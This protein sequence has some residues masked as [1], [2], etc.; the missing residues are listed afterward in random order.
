MTKI[1]IL[2]VDP[3]IVATGFGLISLSK[4]GI[5]SVAGGTVRP[6]TKLSMGQRLL[7]IETYLQ[8]LLARWR[9]AMGAMEA[10]FV[11]RDPGAALKLGGVAGVC[12]ST[13]ARHGLVLENM[14]PRHIK[15]KV[16]GRGS[17]DK[18]A[19]E[20]AVRRFVRNADPDSE[21]ASDGYGAAL[22]LACDCG[23]VDLERRVLSLKAP[24]ETSI[25]S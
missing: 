6:D 23:L 12:L 22:T 15:Q 13:A 21:H 1:L 5:Q 25:S 14:A 10:P 18:K 20:A 19:V 8:S 4:D 3:G 17:A 24:A 7:H 16:C 11:G 9:P 2:G